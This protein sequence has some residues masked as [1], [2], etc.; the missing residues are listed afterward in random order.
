M[1]LASTQT[2]L[3]GGGA[4]RFDESFSG[5]RCTELLHGAWIAHQ[6]LWLS[7]S[8]SLQAEL[9]ERVRWRSERRI[10]YDRMVEV[11]RLL[12]NPPSPEP[13]ILKSMRRQLSR[14]F[15]RLLSSLSLAY[16]RNGN[17]SVAMHGDRMGALN[18]D[19]VIAIVSLGEPRRFLLRSKDRQSKALSFD[20][21]WGDLLVMGGTCQDSYEHGVPKTPRS[22]A[23]RMSLQFRE[24]CPK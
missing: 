4:P 15:G 16:Y 11:P 9:R 17:D 6:P 18:S 3:F 7:G 23:P 24:Q 21:G 2:V 5:L 19:T 14:R 12:G 1:V 10:M 8:N 22:T 20:V 13:E